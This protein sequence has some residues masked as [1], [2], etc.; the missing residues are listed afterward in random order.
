MRSFLVATLFLIGHITAFAQTKNDTL[1]AWQHYKKADSLLEVKNH[2]ESILLFKKAL[3]IYE[4]EEAW[5]RV[6]SCYNKISEN[7]RK[8][9][10]LEKSL[11]NAKKAMEITNIYL[12]KNTEEEA[13][14]YDNI[15]YYYEKKGTFNDVLPNFKKALEIR[16][17]L[18]PESHYWIGKSYRNIS[19][20]C[21]DTQK[22]QDAISYC[23]KSLNIY[24]N[25]FGKE[26]QN[27]GDIYND[28]G[29]IYRRLYKYD[30]ALDFY[31]KSLTITIKN[32]GENDIGTGKRYLNLGALYT[33]LRQQDQALEHYEKA[34]SIFKKHKQKYPLGLAY[35]QT[36][37]ILSQRGE[38]EKALQYS[39][40]SL[41]LMKE[42]LGE[43]HPNIGNVYANLGVMIKNSNPE[44]SLSYYT[45]SLE[46]HKK[47]YGENHFY[48]AQGYDNIGMYYS[49]SKKDYD[50][51]LIYHNKAL[52]IKRSAFSENHY[53]VARSYSIIGFIYHNKKQYSTA[54]DYYK[55]GLAICIGLKEKNHYLLTDS[56]NSI[57]ETLYQQR[58]YTSAL[59]YFDKA[60]DNNIKK[61]KSNY[62]TFKPEDYYYPDQLS[63]TL[64]YKAKT[65]LER[66]KRD[67]TTKDLEQSILLYQDLDKLTDY[68]WQS[69][70][71]YNDKIV[72]AKQA[73]E[74]FTEAIATQLE[75]YNRNPDHRTL[76]KAFYYTRKSKSNILKN[77]LSDNNAKNFS[78]VSKEITVLEKTLKANHAFYQSQI[79]EEQSKDSI[80]SIRIQKY[81]SNLFDVSQRQDSLAK[82]LE[83]KYPKYY[84]LKHQKNSISNKT[85]QQKL[86]EQTTVLEFFTADTITYAFTISKHDVSVKELHTP[87]LQENIN[88]LYNDI[89]TVHNKN[90]IHLGHQ[91]HTELI[92]PIK[93]KLVGDKLIIIPDGPLWHLNFELLL[94]EKSA[95]NSKI[96]ELPYLLRDFA[97][98]YANSA[99][100]L[101]NP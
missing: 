12:P 81:E 58:Q 96:N 30:T 99:T 79:A 63:E 11:R 6:A 18:Y 87:K 101:F 38:N 15:G 86:D 59:S 54:L 13:H 57:G 9:L 78:G 34:L 67:G 48:I 27:I 90:Y 97:I 42:V 24:L 89:T 20:S 4:K 66:S 85:I 75:Q 53:G 68:S 36:G 91:L 17:K 76:E 31:K 71:N 84:Q 88:A 73:K 8:K 23:E 10:A 62:S 77:L 69:Y 80:D 93:D 56:Y 35:L 40:K 49:S 70:Q 5:E 25:I 22:Y 39:K 26:H 2:N 1:V 65:L 19:G 3:P 44:K 37:I 72:F 95:E 64:F 32:L 83:S 47:A 46:I 50:T 55:K 33:M 29:I 60:I 98:S 82:V 43:D 92:A 94:T 21:I 74:R 16:K 51:A 61:K 45:K 14:A 28:L 41:E 100:L 52:E 7:Q